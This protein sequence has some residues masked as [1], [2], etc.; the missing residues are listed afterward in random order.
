MVNSLNRSF[1]SNLSRVL[2]VA[3]PATLSSIV[4]MLQLVIDM[5]MLGKLSLQHI[6][7]IGVSSQYIMI[8]NMLLTILTVATSYTLSRAFGANRK[9]TAYSA[10]YT[11]L[12]IGIGVSILFIVFISYFA[13]DF[14]ILLVPNDSYIV[15]IGVNYI[16]ILAFS[17]PFLFVNMVIFTAFSVKKD[18]KT[19]LYIKMVTVVI[20]VALNYVFIFGHFGMPRLEEFGAASTTLFAYVLTSVIYFYLILS[21]KRELKLVPIFNFNIIKRGIIVGFYSATDRFLFFGSFLFFTGLLTRYGTDALVAYQIGGRVENFATIPGMAFAL[22]TTAFV[23]QH[24]GAKRPDL[25]IKDTYYIANLA[26]IFM[27]ILG[28]FMIFTPELLSSIFTDNPKAI[29]DASLYLL[30]I[31]IVIIPL[32]YTMV[33]G[34]SLEVAGFAK[35]KLKINIFSFWVFRLL[36]IYIIYV[37]HYAMIY[38]FIVISCEIVIKSFIYNIMFIK[39]KKYFH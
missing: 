9:N 10:L 18:S 19:P 39:K 6:S 2:S 4:D 20:N 22:T 14:M 11:V 3:I 38:I 8:V 25:A 34:A 17:I 32:A 12:V 30:C 37:K 1:F 29:Y 36:P 35:E 26:S 31:G 27:G 28:L 7:A 24:F 21:C 23:G 13:R 33:I 16:H 15:T 5:I